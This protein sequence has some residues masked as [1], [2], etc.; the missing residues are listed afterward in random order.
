MKVLFLA[1]GKSERLKPLTSEKTKTLLELDGVSILEHSVRS[2]ISRG[3]KDYVFVSGHGH[4]Y[5]ADELERLSKI[6]KFSYEIVFNSDYAVKNNCYSVLIALEHLDDHVLLIN[7]DVVYDPEILDSVR[8]SVDTSLVIDNY[9]ILTPES[10]KVY[11]DKSRVTHIHK[12]L[13]IKKSF[14][15]YIGISVINKNHLS[16]LK[17]SLKKIVREDPDQYYEDG[18]ALMFKKVPFKVASTKR[19]KWVEVDDFRDLR[20]AKNLL[21]KNFK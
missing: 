3:Y 13:D 1:A 9:K 18:F 20:K 7:S 19:R 11:A 16:L 4:N 12:G 14:G 6:Q 5:L 21:R 10:M 15:E 8:G 2:L 17:S